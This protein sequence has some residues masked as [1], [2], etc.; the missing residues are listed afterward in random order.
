MRGPN[1]GDQE[2]GLVDATA[3]RVHRSVTHEVVDLVVVGDDGEL[4][5]PGQGT[6]ERAGFGGDV[7]EH[8][9]AL[10]RGV[11]LAN[12][13]RAEALDE[14]GP[15][16]GAHARAGEQAQRVVG[17][18]RAR[19]RVDEGAAHLPGI[20]GDR[21]PV[22]PDLGPKALGLELGGEGQAR[23]PDERPAH[24]HQRARGVVEG[25]HA[26]DGVAARQQAGRRGPVGRHGPPAVA[27]VGLARRGP[28]PRRHD[29]HGE[30]RRPP[31][32]GLVPARE[33]DEIGI[34][35]LH[36]EDA[37][38]QGLVFAVAAAAEDQDLG[39][40]AARVC[41]SGLALGG[42][43]VEGVAGVE[44]IADQGVEAGVGEGIAEDLEPLPELTAAAA[45]GRAGLEQHGDRSETIEGRDHGEVGGTPRHQHPHL[46]AGLDPASDQARDDRV[47]AAIG[48]GVGEG[49]PLP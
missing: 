38:G 19:R 41:A 44:G 40:H 33:R 22:A 10:G 49:A 21:R 18:G 39:Q 5:D 17:L 4:V 48:L 27:D 28:R 24:G 29:R 37:R 31:R 6:P 14:R 25:E 2:P 23:A 30:V 9:L 32:V 36:V 42:P 1:L 16:L 20:K 7:G 35:G 12:V 8:E 11:E 34:D 26:V 47:D 15:Q 43:R 46:P 45:G 3:P 13:D